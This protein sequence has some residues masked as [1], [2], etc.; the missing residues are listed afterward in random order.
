[1]VGVPTA[2]VA[3]TGVAM[4]VDMGAGIGVGV[5]TIAAMSLFVIVQVLSSPEA[6]V[7]LPLESQSPLN[8]CP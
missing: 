8:V 6:S 4:A 5:I 3:L 2:L 7:T 1:M